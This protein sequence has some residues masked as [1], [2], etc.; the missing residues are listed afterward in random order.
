VEDARAHFEFFG[1]RVAIEGWPEVVAALELDFAWFRTTPDGTAD[2]TIDVQPGTPSF[3]S[4]PPVRASFTTTRNVVY[5]ADSRTIVD[6]F[7]R[8]LVIFDRARRTV[9]VQGDE[10]HLV[11]EAIYLLVL[12]RVGEHLDRRRL[13]RLHAMAMTGAQN[14][15][16]VLLPAGGGKTT[17][18]LRALRE[19]R[20]RLISDDT[21]LLDREGRLHAFPLRL[22]V[23]ERVAAELPANEVRRIERFEFPAKHALAL[24]AFSNQIASE[25]QPLRHIV[26]GQRSLGNDAHLVAIPRRRAVGPLFRDGVVGLGIAQMAE[27]VLQRGWFDVMRNGRVAT[28]RAAICSKA[29]SQARTWELELGRDGERN[30]AAL[31]PLLS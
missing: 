31:E 24:E 4:L 10:R 2:A 22:G 9:L 28:M 30:W 1:Y 14:G 29:L 27:Y 7:G 15:V 20:V 17:L 23:N 12:N 25:P 11:H 6:Y 18:A 5:Q 16:V 26:L 8:A 21:P 19:P 13:L 3:D